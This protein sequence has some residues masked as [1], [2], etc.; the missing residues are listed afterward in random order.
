MT[1]KIWLKNYARGVPADADC[2]AYPSVRHLFESAVRR[3][4]A[5]PAFTTQCIGLCTC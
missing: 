5:L 2:D 1:A 4:R 3:Y